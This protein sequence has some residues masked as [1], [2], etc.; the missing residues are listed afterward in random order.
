MSAQ[1]NVTRLAKNGKTQSHIKEVQSLE[2]NSRL[3][4]V[5]GKRAGTVRGKEQV[6]TAR[7][8]HLR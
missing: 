4:R 2:M 8:P 7:C 1:S 6:Y 3:E 5:W